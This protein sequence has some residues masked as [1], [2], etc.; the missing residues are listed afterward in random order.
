MIRLERIVVRGQSDAGPFEGALTLAPGLQVVSAR[1]SY[2]K[3]LAVKAVA[4]CLGIEPIFGIPDNEPTCFPPA[5]REELEFA[6]RQPARVLSSECSISLI[7]DDG[8][9]LI[10]VRAIRG[11][12]KMVRVE[13]RAIDG[14]VRRSKLL[15]RRETM[16][17]EHG[18]LQRFLFEWLGWPRQAVTTFRGNAAEIY[19][20]NLAPAFYIDQEEGWTDIQALQIG[21][22]G[23]Q[24]IAEIAVEYL[25]G[26]TEAIK[27]RVARQQ[28]SQRNAYLRETARD[29]AERV[30][31]VFLRRG[32]RVEWS[33]NGPLSEI[34]ARWSSRTLR[35]ILA[36]DANVDF[37]AIK[38]LLNERVENLRRALTS[39]PIDESNATAPAGVSQRV[40]QLKQSRHTLNSE[41]NTLRTQHE[42]TSELVE[43]LEHRIQSA[44]DLLRLKTTGVGRL[45]H[46]ECPTCHRDLDPSTFALTQQ[47]EASVSS[48]IEALKR[49]R[50][51][52]RQNLE[53]IDASL[54]TTRGALANVD[55]D[56][57]EA[58]R[59]LLTVTAA[60]GTVR[61]QIAQTAANLTAAERESDRVAE[62]VEE[63]DEL[64]QQVNGW[65]TEAS[66]LAQ[67]R[68]DATDLA[69]R[70][71]AFL[72]ALR[73]YLAAL[74]HSALSP[75]N[76][77]LLEIDEQYVPY[78]NGHRLRSLGSASDQSRLI[79]S[80]SLALAA[81]SKQIRAFHPG[82][83]ILDEP[84]QQNPDALHRQ[85]F[86]AFLSQELAREAK[87]QTIIFTWLADDDITRLRQQG[88][89]VIT[90]EG[91]HFLQLVPTESG[92]NGAKQ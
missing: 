64:Q 1:N 47:S 40:V 71:L 60:V 82:I 8:R 73:R 30:S 16:Q 59:S 3:S 88:T 78:L 35:G 87:F 46:V 14:Q 25:L 18:G 92:P 91:D 69:A 90:P 57:R 75:E 55:L 17:D 79:A 33:G 76:A 83:V 65:I 2:G 56:L 36:D 48:H 72:S 39:E 11:D 24:Q 66:A 28:T 85:L 63:I 86:L 49:D 22:Y 77:A 31:R 80:Y 53:S 4:W 42:E 9:H 34:L 70:R 50:D 32:W 20:E 12:C 89:S 44:S 51:M 38:A 58:E 62:S 10:L 15:A 13:E 81:A 67:I 19:L 27:A 52:M 54:T 21:R 29:I 41:L 7:H 26:A 61:E 5:V 23:Q 37:G 43:S 45:D 84:L 68:L 74:G 6:G